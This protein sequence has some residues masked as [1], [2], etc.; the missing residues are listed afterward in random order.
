M[1]STSSTPPRCIVILR[2]SARNIYNF[3]RWSRKPATL[4]IPCTSAAC[5][6]RPTENF[7]ILFLTNGCAHDI[8]KIFIQ[9]FD[10]SVR[11]FLGMEHA[12]CIY[13]ETCG[14]VPVVEHNG[15]FYACDHYVT[16]EYK[17]GNIHERP[18]AR[19]GRGRQAA[20]V[21]PEKWTS[22]PKY[23]RE[24]SLSMCNGGCPKTASSRLPRRSGLN[25][26]GAGLKDLS[27]TA[28][29][30]FKNSPTWSTPAS[31]GKAHGLVRA[32]DAKRFARQAGRNDPC[33]CGSGKNI[34]LLRRRT[35]GC[36]IPFWIFDQCCPNVNRTKLIGYAIHGLFRRPQ[37]VKE[38][39]K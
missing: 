12:L 16:P 13:R 38:L 39:V 35:A 18:L 29:P 11:P 8:G 25:Y 3:C 4:R 31:P 26:L 1:T 20:R 33:P 27:T 21:R 34:R 37:I 24:R 28:K 17:I 6:R 30:Y 36:L 14:D 5:R 15:D 23:C 10:E 2:R 7:S 9:L 22:L 32:E 19:D